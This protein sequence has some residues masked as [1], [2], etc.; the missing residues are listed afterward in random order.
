MQVSSADLTHKPTLRIHLDDVTH[1]ASSRFVSLVDCARV[2]PNAI[3]QVVN[4]LY[5]PSGLGGIPK[6]RS[7]TLVL[8][9]MG[10][11]AYTTGLSLDDLHKEIHMS[12][13]YVQQFAKEP[14]RLRDEAVG[15]ITHEM[16]H[17]F[18][19]NCRG[20]APGGLIEGIADWVRLKAGLAPPHWNRSPENRGKT[21]DEGYQKTAWFLDWLEQHHGAGTISQMN[22]TMGREAY[23][24][25]RF[26][27]SLFGETV[28]TLWQWYKESWEEPEPPSVS[29]QC[30]TPSAAGSEPEIIELDD[31]EEERQP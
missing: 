19:H 3:Q 27:N 5:K 31:A 15:V 20:T 1:P 23:D 17:C 12:L 2:L 11:V 25:G 29:D 13:D 26:W 21:W 9:E 16:V 7:V 14:L 8:R 6:V 18:Q 10:G 28:D 30:G 4:H 22:E 24:E